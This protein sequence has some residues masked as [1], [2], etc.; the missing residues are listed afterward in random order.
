M[1]LIVIFSLLLFVPIVKAQEFVNED[2]PV[3]VAQQELC[4]STE[5]LSNL[6]KDMNKQKKIEAASGV[7]DLVRMRQLG[8]AWVR[9]YDRFTTAIHDP[10]AKNVTNCPEVSDADQLVLAKEIAKYQ[11]KTG[12]KRGA[13]SM[14]KAIKEGSK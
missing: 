7:K 4:E 2:D 6:A 9:G 10:N 13:A 1:R 3:D 12:D 5:E 8:D 14:K 11:E